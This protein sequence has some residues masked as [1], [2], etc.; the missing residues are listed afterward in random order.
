MRVA[1]DCCSMAPAPDSMSSITRSTS[2]RQLSS[3]FGLEAAGDHVALP[4]QFAV[5]LHAAFGN[6]LPVELG[7]GVLDG[8]DGP[9]GVG[10]A[11]E[12]PEVPWGRLVDGLLLIDPLSARAPASGAGRSV[13]RAA[14]LACASRQSVLDVV[15]QP[16][17]V[18]SFLN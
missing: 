16:H 2:D 8:V 18:R 11:G 15:D 14:A 5:H 9:A 4:L 3:L 10:R 7:D 1:A 12:G 17:S 6:D 13:C